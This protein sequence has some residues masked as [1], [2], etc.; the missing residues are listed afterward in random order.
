MH[1]DPRYLLPESVSQFKRFFVHHPFL[2][3]LTL[4]LVYGGVV[5]VL[6]WRFRRTDSDVLLFAAIVSAI[7]LL[8]GTALYTLAHV[9]GYYLGG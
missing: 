3:S 9:K 2:A 1:R 4:F 6:R 5:Q 7:I 8:V